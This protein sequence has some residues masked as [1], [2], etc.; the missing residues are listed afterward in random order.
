M[1]KLTTIL[2]IVLSISAYS[3]E[4]WDYDINF[5][6]TNQFFRLNIDTISNPNNI[7]QIGEPQKTV[8][9]SAYSIVRKYKITTK[10]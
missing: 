4:Y 6:D 10:V 3:Q 1:N 5:E 9:T 7:W 2:F 8:F